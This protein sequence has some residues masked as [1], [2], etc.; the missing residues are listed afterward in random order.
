M[1]RMRIKQNPLNPINLLTISRLFRGVLHTFSMSHRHDQ[2]RGSA[3]PVGI[4]AGKA[5]RDTIGGA[6]GMLGGDKWRAP[7]YGPWRSWRRENAD[8]SRLHFGTFAWVLLD[9]SLTS[10]LRLL[11]AY[12]PLGGRRGSYRA[13]RGS[14]RC[15]RS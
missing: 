15:S 14:L 13:H 12:T 9:V 7:R 4:F 10:G 3:L 6:A 2:L 1:K 8:I 5:L 11:V